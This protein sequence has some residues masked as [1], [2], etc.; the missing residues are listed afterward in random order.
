[1]MALTADGYGGSGGTCIFNKIERI[2]MNVYSL[3]SSCKGLPKGQYGGLTWTE[4][5]EFSI[6]SM[7]LKLTLVPET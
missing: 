5:V 1:M 6:T 7:Q 3:K 2:A 4:N